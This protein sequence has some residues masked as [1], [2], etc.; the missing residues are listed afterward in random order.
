MPFT[1]TYGGLGYPL[2]MDEVVLDMDDAT[3]ADPDT[4]SFRAI[5]M[6]D[7]NCDMVVDGLVSSGGGESL[8]TVGS[9]GSE[10][11]QNNDVITL[12]VKGSVN[13]ALEGYQLGMQFDQNKLQYLGSSAGN[14]TDYN[15][16]NFGIRD[17]EIRALWN[18]NNFQPEPMATQKTLFKL[19]FKVL[20]SFCGLSSVF[21]LNDAILPAK[22]Y[23]YNVEPIAANIVLTYQKETPKGKLMSLYPN[24]T[25]NSATFSFQL[26]EPSIVTIRLSDYLGG[27]LNMSQTYN[28]GTSNYTFPNLSSLANGSLNYTVQIGNLTYSG[29]LVKSQP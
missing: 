17:G 15:P 10:C 11:V 14:L 16:D 1:A 19:H 8:V 12:E 25:T 29:I 28:A 18:K 27:I 5:K 22:F 4:W 7:V 23:N 9:V 3:A 2:Y 24:P 13:Q 6:G 21:Y 26:D 20:N